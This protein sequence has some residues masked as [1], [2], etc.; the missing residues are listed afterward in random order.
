MATQPTKLTVSLNDRDSVTALLYLAPKKQRA[1]ITLILGHGA[2]AGQLHPFMTLFANGLAARGIDVITFNFIYMEQRRHVPDPKA[3]LESC[4]RA[5]IDAAQKNKNLKGNRLAIGGKSMGGRIASQVAAESP[6]LDLAGL[7]FLGYPLH[8][9]GRPDKLRDAHLK[10]I[11]SPM[12][13]IQGARDSFG[14]PDELRA[15]IK[16]DHLPATLHPIEGGD[17]SLKVPKSLDV[18]QEQ[19]YESVMNEIARWLGSEVNR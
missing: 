8:P 16:R 15:V 7:V 2:G 19:V 1:G 10:D 12:L 6:E 3:K 11:K 5:V 14:T 17:H 9:P 4:Y 18:P 13:F